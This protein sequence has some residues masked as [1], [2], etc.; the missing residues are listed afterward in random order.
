M[1]VPAHSRAPRT[2]RRRGLH[3]PR[4]A[5]KGKACSFHRSASPTQ[6]RFAGLCVGGRL[7]RPESPTPHCKI[8]GAQNTVPGVDSCR[9]TGPWCGAKFWPAPFHRRA[10]F[11][12]AVAEGAGR[13]A[14]DGA[15]PMNRGRAGQCPA[16]TGGR[17]TI[18]RQKTGGRVWDP[19]LQYLRRNTAKPEDGRARPRP[20][21][22]FRT[23]HRV[24][25]NRS[26]SVAATVTGIACDRN[27]PV[28]AGPRPARR[29]SSAEIRP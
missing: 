27:C 1:G 18:P 8:S 20:H 17:G 16:P 4:F 2:P 9:A 6:T 29:F 13:G 19:P 22:D 7:R 10:W 28:G 23:F 21:G 5:R 26:G 15:V 24:R 25:R 11:R 12:P 3:I 14:S